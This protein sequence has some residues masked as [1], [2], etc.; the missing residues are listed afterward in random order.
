MRL[1]FLSFYFRPDLSAGSFRA[2]ALA[3]ALDQ[4]LPPP[5]ALHIISTQPN[6]YKSFREAAP[7]EERVGRTTI[8]RLPIGS[9]A[10]GLADQSVAFASYSVRALWRALRTP[11][12]AV[13]ATSSR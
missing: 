8:L 1:L 9:H 11:S 4:D 13:F 12:D 7:V 5:G 6:R 3:E 10:G 2:T